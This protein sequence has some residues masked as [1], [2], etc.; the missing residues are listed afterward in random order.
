MIYGNENILYIADYNP[1][2]MAGALLIITVAVVLAAAVEIKLLLF[3]IKKLKS[4]KDCAKE[5]IAKTRFLAKREGK[6]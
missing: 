6:S 1:D 4:A 2:M 3:K 5:T